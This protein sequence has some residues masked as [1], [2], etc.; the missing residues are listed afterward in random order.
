M[1]LGEFLGSSYQLPD[2]S[3]FLCVQ[4][5][6][7]NASQKSPIFLKDNMLNINFDVTMLDM[8]CDHVTVGVWDASLGEF[9]ANKN[10]TE[11]W[12]LRIGRHTHT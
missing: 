11:G 9:F 12:I 6:Q 7:E 3:D 4:S 2:F 1:I 8:S 10:R 5:C